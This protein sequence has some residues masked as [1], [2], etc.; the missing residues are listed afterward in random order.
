MVGVQLFR[1]AQAGNTDDTMAGDA[2]LLGVV[3]KY[4]AT[5]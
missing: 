1:D 3:V 4:T 2:L 5:R